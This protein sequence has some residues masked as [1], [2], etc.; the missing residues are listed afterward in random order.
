MI[1]WRCIDRFT[2]GCTT[3]PQPDLRLEMSCAA[4]H[5]YSNTLAMIRSSGNW[6]IEYLGE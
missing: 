3:A 6:G 5:Q 4:Q 1:L 2:K